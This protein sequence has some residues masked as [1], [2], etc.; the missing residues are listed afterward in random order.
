MEPVPA[1]P[2]PAGPLAVRWLAHDVSPPRA[3]ALGRA[4]LALENA[5]LAPWQGL[6]LAYHWLDALGNPIVWDGIR[7]ELPA[8]APGEQTEVEARVRAP[9][10]PGSYRLAFDLVLEHRYWLAEL[11]NVPLELAVEVAP[12]VEG[13]LEEVAELHLAAGLEPAPDWAERVLAAH[14]EGYAL[15]AGAIDAPGRTLARW[16]PG[17]GRVPGFP[18]PLLC[19]SI[20]EGVEAERLP[21]VEGLPAFSPPR[22][23]PWVYDGRIVLRARRRFGRRRG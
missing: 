2:V 20:L 11:G 9:I 5:G 14:R 1:H 21:D 10:P 19:P 7:T 22:E 13:R 12:R 3:G 8:L 17:P 4:R 6:L 15:V 23:E 16:A 18:G